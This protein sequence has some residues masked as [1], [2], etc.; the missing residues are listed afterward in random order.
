MSEEQSPA[1][2]APAAA[3]KTPTTRRSRPTRASS[4][5]A[6]AQAEVALEPKRQDPFQSAKR[7][8]PD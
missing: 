7:V 1:D 2:A 8:W 6:R 3:A 5:T 4:A